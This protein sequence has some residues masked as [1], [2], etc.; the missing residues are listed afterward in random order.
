MIAF[1]LFIGMNPIDL[2]LLT[3][4]FVLL[5]LILSKAWQINRLPGST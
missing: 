1:A 2:K 3:A 4:V 5:T